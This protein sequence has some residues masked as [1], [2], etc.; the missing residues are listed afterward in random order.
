MWRP[1][2]Q[3]INLSEEKIPPKVPIDKKIIENFLG[4]RGIG[5]FLA[6]HAIPANTSAR[7]IDNTIIIGTGPLTG[8]IFP[9]GGNVTATF[10]SPHTNTLFTSTCTGKLGGALENQKLNFLQIDGAAKTPIYLEIDEFADINFRDARSIWKK[11]IIESDDWLRNRYGD[12]ACILTIGQ[13]AVNQIVFAGAA[14][15]RINF[16]RRGGLGAVLASKNLKA[17]VITEAPQVRQ[18]KR[19]STDILDVLIEELESHEWHTLL[20]NHGTFGLIFEAIENGVLPAKNLSRVLNLDPLKIS[21]FNGFGKEYQ[22]WQCPVR[23]NRNSYQAFVSLGPNLKI[24]DL[25]L[26]QKSISECERE[27]LDPLSTGAA[28]AALSNIQE[29]RRKLLELQTEYE[30]G[31]INV[32]KR[33]ED[34]IFRRNLGEQL[35]RGESYLYQ[36]TNE[37]APFIKSQIGSMFYYPKVLGLALAT[38]I[39]P[40]GSAHFHSD[41]MIWPELMG[42]PFKLD[43][44]SS[45]GKAR[46]VV[47]F[48]NLI[49]FLDSL[50]VCSRYLPFFLRIKPFWKILPKRIL[51]FMFQYLSKPMVSQIGLSFGRLELILKNVLEIPWHWK[52][53]FQVGQRI[54]LV[55]RVFNTRMG[56]SRKE[57]EFDYFLPKRPDFNK[58]MSKLVNEYYHIKGVNKNGLVK[59]KTLEQTGLLGLISI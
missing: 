20:Q 7:G 23:C 18:D 32:Y 10:K 57:D 1:Q 12:A 59:G 29:D 30:W 45:H 40:F 9:S 48:E 27:A 47:L 24:L 5:V 28:L 39:S 2:L 31:N 54:T 41:Y 42:Y 50:V 25:P 34:I 44:L 13:A 55:E 37:P 36:L 26:I 14:V 21:S 58:T 33:I 53:I 8:S 19:L 17:I 38:A 51:S 43:P 3:T 56:M 15:D 46:T 52:Q 22:C 16:F 11:D 6:Y 4:G 49:A 35:A